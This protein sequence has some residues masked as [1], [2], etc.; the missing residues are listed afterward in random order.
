MKLNT[1]RSSLENLGTAG[2]GGVFRDEDSNWVLGYSRHIVITSSFI[3][4]LWP[5][6]DG[7]SLCINRNSLAVDIELDA[8]AIIDVLTPIKLI[9]LFLPLWMIAGSWLP[10]F[11]RFVFVTA[12]RKQTSVLMDFS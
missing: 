7:L 3:A 2:S 5:M 12:S 11:S 9:L 6:Q 10:K 4:E 8:K 1:D